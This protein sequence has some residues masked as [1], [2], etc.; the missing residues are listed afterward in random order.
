MSG[1]GK[2]RLGRRRC[3]GRAERR[4]EDGATASSARRARRLM[5]IG[6]AV[7]LLAGVIV[8]VLIGGRDS[9]NAAQQGAIQGASTTTVER[10]S[11]LETD[12]ETGTLGYCGELNVYGRLA[13][14]VTWVPSA[15]TVVYPDHALYGV[16]GK[17]VYL[18]DGTQPAR[19]AFHAGMS[20]GA[21]VRQ[22]NR[23]LRSMG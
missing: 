9:P 19:R 13:G 15:G 4:E 22:L 18:L 20:D 3:S 5:V 2:S 14:T 23:G 7:A 8:A 6:G 12:I 1:T 17:G 10:R 21:D 11:L 16:E